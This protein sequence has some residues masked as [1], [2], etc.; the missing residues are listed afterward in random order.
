MNDPF[1]ALLKPDGHNDPHTVSTG[2]VDKSG[3]YRLGPAVRPTIHQHN[4]FL[5]KY[6]KREPTVQE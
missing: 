6:P 1:E 2:L 3:R 4:G 5:D